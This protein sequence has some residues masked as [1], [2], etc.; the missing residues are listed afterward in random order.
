MLKRALAVALLLATPALA[1]EEEEGRA[2]RLSGEA[3]SAVEGLPTRFVIDARLTEGSG[4]LQSEV[5]GWFAAIAPESE[6]FFGEIEGACVEERC[7]LSVSYGDQ[8]LVIT[9]DMAKVG[10]AFGPSTGKAALKDPEGKAG[11]SVSVVLT[12]FKDRP[13]GLNQP[14]AEAGAFT[15]QQITEW[16]MWAGYPTG[17]FNTDDDPPGSAEHEA[18]GRWQAAN[19]RAP[20]SGLFVAADVA[21]LRAEAQAAQATVGWTPLNTPQAG[22]KAGYPAKQLR[23]LS[24]AASPAERRYA[25]PD[26]QAVLLTRIDPPLD[27]D[28]WDAFIKAETDESQGRD[29]SGYM[30]VNDDF[31]L[32][33]TQN[34]R[35]VSAYYF[36]GDKG[37]RRMEFSY[38]E[39]DA[40]QWDQTAQILQYAYR[41]GDAER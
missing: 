24:A 25:S 16:L 26:G 19:E 37:L 12:P 32:N 3:A 28:A 5:K 30:R 41:A 18:F 23:S 27:D 11:A 17:S 13:L 39:G 36:N 14:L 29:T 35:A 34:G 31:E 6:S 10:A 33:Y 7:A 21:A 2:L 1:E 15:G 38:P 40:Q 9:G 22:W 8:D 20:A 4:P